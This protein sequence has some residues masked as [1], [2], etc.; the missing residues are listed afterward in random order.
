M[1]GL[2]VQVKHCNSE[3][4][5]SAE[6]ELVFSR[7]KEGV[8]QSYLSKLPHRETMNDIEAQILDGVASLYPD[9]FLHLEQFVGQNNDFQ[10]KTIAVFD[11]EIQFY[12]SW[13]KFIEKF[14]TVGLSCC[15]P[16]VSAQTKEIY[17]RSG[18]DIA[19]ADKLIHENK[20]VVVNDFSLKGKERILVISGPNQGGKTTFARAFGQLHYLAGLGCPVA[21]TDA[22]L[23][24][25]D[26]LFTHFEKE[27]NIKNLRGKL[28]DEL[29]RIHAILEKATTN[30]LIVI[31]EIFTSTTLQDQ[32]F[33]SS[34]IM[35][36]L[37]RLDITGVW[38][39]FI[40][41]LARYSEKTVSMV[42][43]VVPENT[44]QRTFKITRRPADGLAYALSIAE[45]YRLTHTLLTKRLEK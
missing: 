14:K 7:F 42:S 18:Y 13:L 24:L 40:D 38:V 8:V 36:K 15:Y 41:E 3:P 16:V 2:R 11:R 17:S 44:A 4:D 5:Y 33:L 35:D 30:S 22:R 6:V 37:I 27:E 19:L 39:T 1:D 26:Q 31:N 25:F 28:Q 10:D 23:F 9:Y 32:V 29:V 21:G 20:S 43:S 45:K 34:Q 12:L